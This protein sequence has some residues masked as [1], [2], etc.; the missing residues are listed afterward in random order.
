MNI[1]VIYWNSRG[2]LIED[3]SSRTAPAAEHLVISVTSFIQR[4]F[5]IVSVVLLANFSR[6]NDC[7]T[8]R[9]VRCW[10]QMEARQTSA[11]E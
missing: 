8:D 2:D 6:L 1:P 9:S 7:V 5:R 3:L 11:P 10:T 4:Q